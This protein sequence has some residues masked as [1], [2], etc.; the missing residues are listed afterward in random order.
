MSPVVPKL[1]Y[2]ILAHSFRSG[3]AHFDSW[4]WMVVAGWPTGLLAAGMGLAQARCVLL[5]PAAQIDGPDIHHLAAPC[6]E[7]AVELA[8]E[9]GGRALPF[10][11]LQYALASA[12]IV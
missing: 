9:F 6:H 5:A 4:L 10:S 1:T 3:F 11:E 7:K 12:D 2:F 8:S